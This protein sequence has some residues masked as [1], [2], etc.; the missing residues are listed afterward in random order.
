LSRGLF[1]SWQSPLN[2]FTHARVALKWQ[3][4]TM[5]KS[6]K[7]LTVVAADVAV[8]LQREANLVEKEKKNLYLFLTWAAATCDKKDQSKHESVWYIFGQ[9]PS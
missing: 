2:A 5:K 9:K 4:D 3:S 1:G 7:S 6:N 8:A